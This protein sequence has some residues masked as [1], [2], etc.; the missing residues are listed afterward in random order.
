MT[1]TNDSHFW[2]I[3]NLY[4]AC[5]ERRYVGHPLPPG[6]RSAMP[7]FAAVMNTVH[8]ALNNAVENGCAGELARVS[9]RDLA[10]DLAR[11]DADLE[12]EDIEVLTQGVRRW[13]GPA[14]EA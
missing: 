14:H 12:G 1:C 6:G 8:A 7:R 4:C 9:D 11:F 10:Y 3:G 2:W 5:G 13:R